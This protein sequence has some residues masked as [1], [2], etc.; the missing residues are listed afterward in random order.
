MLMGQRENIVGIKKYKSRDAVFLIRQGY[1]SMHL[2]KVLTECNLHK[3]KSQCY[4]VSF[5]RNLV[6]RATIISTTVTVEVT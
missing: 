1:R 3:L 4:K 5:M 2:G 6:K